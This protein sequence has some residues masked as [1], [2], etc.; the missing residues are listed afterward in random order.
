ML[1]SQFL[2][3]VY[4]GYFGA[5][6]G[7]LML[8]AYGILGFSNIH[9]ANGIK[10]LN[11][12]LINGIAGAMFCARG[13][14]NWPQAL[15]CPSARSSAAMPARRR[16]AAGAKERPPPRHLHRPVA[17]GGDVLQEVL[18]LG[19]RTY[20]LRTCTMRELSNVGT[21]YQP[22]RPQDLNSLPQQ[23]R[24]LSYS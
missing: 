9:E 14:V 5:G 20:A 1:F 7:I 24:P 21:E 22:P 10:N 2:V 15:V 16:A 17:V 18:G 12:M 6:I 19:L 23:F 13:L 8:A 4:G 3:G 11:A